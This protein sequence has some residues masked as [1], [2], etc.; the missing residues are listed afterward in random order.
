MKI[1]KAKLK[2][3]IYQAE[4]GDPIA[5]GAVR[6][7]LR[8]NKEDSE[9]LIFEKISI[10]IR[11]IYLS[12]LTFDD[13]PFHKDID[14][15]YAGQI[16]SYL[17]T[18]KPKYKGAMFIGYR[19]SAK[20]SRI[21]FNEAYLTI[22]CGDLLDY[23]SVVSED[24]SS[25]DQFTMDMF[26]SFAFSRISHYYPNLISLEQLKKKESQTM[27]KFTTLTGVTYS[28]TSSRKSRRG[29]VKMDITEEGDVETKRPKRTIFDDIENETTIRS[30]LATQHI[31]SVM[32][33]T[34]DGLDQIVGSWILIGNYL[35]LRGNVAR[36]INKYKND[37]SVYILLI[38]IVD[39]LGVPT[40]PGKYVRTDAEEAEMS[41][42]G[43]KRQS[44]E[45]I[46]R[47]SENFTTEFLNNPK[48]SLVY[49]DDKAL[50]GFDEALLRPESD[51]DDNGLLVIEEPDRN[52]I[53]VIASDAGKGTGGDESTATVIKVSGI[54]FEEVANFKSKRIKPEDFAKFLSTL[55]SRYN[56]ALIIPENNYPGNEVIAFLIP[57][58]NNIFVS[59]VN[60]DSKTGVESKE[61]GINTN[62]KTKPEMF[63][64]AKRVF[65]DRL[66][67]VRSQALYDQI[68]EYPSDDLHVVKQ[69]DGSGGHF[70][71][72][73]SAIIGLW[74]ASGLT[75]EKKSDDAVD[76]RLRKLTNDIFKEPE[77]HR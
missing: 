33:A 3:V 77:T 19:E 49:F 65:L 64:H 36:F 56:T 23:T 76:A 6:E 50:E 72:L 59:H 30:L 22:Y 20:T 60:I 57:I 11:L 21:K 32:S 55:G 15:Y 62:L 34:I 68:L 54:R 4:K 29:N 26:N 31:G 8:P 5:I 38:P 52:S 75:I 12:S 58:Y 69:R 10:F 41:A 17:N 51:R 27:S 45:S 67:T 46:Q 42:K 66:F 40:W 47:T 9:D 74:K 48:R 16:H 71:L 7:T 13:A 24:G 25:A 39:G 63:L 35:S 28:A 43:L 2:G 18:G 1:N 70:D 53:Y 37:S 73:M 14:R 44:V 61:Y